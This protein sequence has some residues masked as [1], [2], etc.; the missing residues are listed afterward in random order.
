MILQWSDNPESRR[1]TQTDAEGRYEF[2]ELPVGKFVLVAS[3]P[4]YVGLQY[5]QRRP[6]ESG[7]PIQL[8]DSETAASIDFAL[9][10]GSVITGRVIDEFGQPLVG[11]QVQARR[12]RYTETGS[13]SL[14]PVTSDATDDRGEF[15]LFSLMPGEYIVDAS[16]RSTASLLSASTNPNSPVE[17]FQPTYYPGTPNAAEAQPISLGVARKQRFRYR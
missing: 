1:L 5:G 12:F 14:F 3:A 2:T 15:R 8:R 13:R 6:Y 16:V 11:A 7:T 17:G 4:G 10:R 9:P